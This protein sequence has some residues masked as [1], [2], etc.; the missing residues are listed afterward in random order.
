MNDFHQAVARYREC[1]R[2]VRNVYFQPADRT[3]AAWDLT[4]GWT[5]VDRLLFNWMVLYPHG[6]QPVEDGRSHPQITLQVQGLFGA[7]AFINR[8]KGKNSGYWDHPVKILRSDECVLTFRQFF[9]FDGLSP[10]DFNYVMVEISEALNNDLNG[11]VALIEWQH[12]EFHKDD[13]NHTSDGIRQP[14]DG[15]PKPSM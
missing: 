11:R 1:S 14:A 5:E 2:H 7:T 6:L 8:E 13:P 4:E 3:S 10:I 12:V 9:D 15:L